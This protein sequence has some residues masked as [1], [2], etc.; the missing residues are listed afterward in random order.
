MQV[1]YQLSYVGATR[2]SYVIAADRGMIRL[3]NDQ[4]C[5][6]VSGAF[7]GAFLGALS[8]ENGA[9]DRPKQA[10]RDQKTQ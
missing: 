3:Q 6:A 9:P 10:P 4:E 5:P 7:F 2:Q 8:G 1:L